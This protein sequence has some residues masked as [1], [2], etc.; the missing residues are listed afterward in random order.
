MNTR[1]QGRDFI[2]IGKVRFSIMAGMKFGVSSSA[3]PF[4]GGPFSSGWIEWWDAVA[5]MLYLDYSRKEG[6]G[7]PTDMEGMK[8]GSH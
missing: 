7:F 2:L 5:S 1:I 4:S 6:S 8:T 3:V